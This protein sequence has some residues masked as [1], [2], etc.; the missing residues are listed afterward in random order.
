MKRFTLAMTAIA[1]L[2]TA[3]IAAAEGVSLD[4]TVTGMETPS[5]VVRIAL[6]QGEEAYESGPPLSGENIDVTG[7][8]VTI[9]FADLEPG[10]YGI[11]MYHD[12]NDDGDMNANPFGMPTEPYA[13]S[14]NAKGRFGPAKWAD[15]SFTVSSDGATQT[16]T[17]K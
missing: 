3:P 14:N 7:D 16:I 2:M 5:G 15:A 10:A 13:F 17:L 8:T 4:V 11:K 9:A 12:I 6:F 1:A